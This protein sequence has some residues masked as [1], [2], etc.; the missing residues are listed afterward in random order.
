ML[1][2]AVLEREPDI[3]AH[4][5]AADPFERLLSGQDLTEAEAHLLFANLVAG[6]LDEAAM[7]ALLVAFRLKGETAEELT[8]AAKALR[9]AAVPFDRPDYRFA[10]SCGTGA[11]GSSSINISTATA[12]VAAAAGLPVAKHGNRSVTS[13]CGSADV[14]EALGANIDLSPAVSRAMLDEIGFC[15][16]YAPSYHPGLRHAGPI[17]RRLKVRTIMNFLGPC[18]NPAHPQ[19]QLLGV[20]DPAKL[21]PVAKTLHAMGV[22][23]AL[24]VHG[25]GLDEVAL[26]GETQAIRLS[27]GQLD[28]LILRPRDAGVRRAAIDAV[29]GGNPELNAARFRALLEG[30]VDGPERDMVLINV[31]ALFM[32]AGM[33]PTLRLG[34][35]LARDTLGSG[36]AAQ[37]LHRYIDASHG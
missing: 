25:A 36:K 30:S 15:F 34:A 8:G 18:L 13:Q 3:S 23:Q 33:T 1:H 32:A 12:F 29:R 11:D 17:R 4:P 26:H 20:A 27:F 24:V 21:E 14:L 28:S 19:V 6:G 35:E 7:A 16:L 31:A 5:T 9:S 2:Q 37:L 22:E 10:D